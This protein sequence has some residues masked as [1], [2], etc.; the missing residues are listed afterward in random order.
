MRRRLQTLH[1]R[2]A[3]GRAEAANHGETLGDTTLIDLSRMMALRTRLD[4]AANN[5]ANTETTGFR[6]RQLSFQEY[7]S[8]VPREVGEKPERPL[9]LVDAAF[10]VTSSTAGALQTTGNPLDL[11]IDGNGYFAV[12]TEQGERY[13]RDG[14]FT[15]DSTGRL[16]TMDGQPVLG[17]SGVISVPPDGG[18]ITIDPTGRISTKRGA[19]GRLRL[20]S[21]ANRA[22]LWAVGGN[23]LASDTAPSET[24][25]ASVRVVQ[26][27]VERSNVQ[28]TF[29]MSRL[30]EI[31]RSY[32]MV[33]GL[34]KNTQDVDDMN[35]L[36]DVPD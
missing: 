25:P 28:P 30:A 18:A 33:G 5:L 17:D 20:V 21:F 11:A 36:A 10:A 23:R 19:L 29:E 1:A 24:N 3:F 13:T 35:K 22:S 7:L 14:S 6:A 15:L 12:R 27:T 34:L 32:D 8:P 2:R 4:V 16:V 31:S 9:S 26:G